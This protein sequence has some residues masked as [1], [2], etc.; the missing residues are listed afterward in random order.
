MTDAKLKTSVAKLSKY[1]LPFCLLASL[2]L[3]FLF[4]GHKLLSFSQLAENYAN[5][6]AFVDEQLFTAL[7]AFG[8]AYIITVALSLPVASFLT[9]AGGALF[10]WTAAAVIICSATS[11]A[12]IAFIAAQKIR[13]EFFVKRT[14][15][16]M[17]KLEAGLHKNTFSYLLALRLIPAVPFWVVNVVPALFGVRL[18]HYVLATFIGITPG[19]LIYVW[20][21]RSFDSLL[22]RGQSPDLSVLSKPA[23]FMPLFALGILSLFPALWKRLRAH[24]QLPASDVNHDDAQI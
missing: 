10:G 17:K 24:Q 20:V 3:F 4:D 9:L 14:T 21:A 7:L 13:N 11:G 15:G 16:F 2:V 1:V 19:T 12:T 18:N 5:L 23:I 8:A 22:T 6:K